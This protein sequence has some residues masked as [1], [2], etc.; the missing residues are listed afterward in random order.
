MLSFVVVGSSQLSAESNYDNLNAEKK[1]LACGMTLDALRYAFNYSTWGSREEI[2]S[3]YVVRFGSRESTEDFYNNY[4]PELFMRLKSYLVEYIEIVRSNSVPVFASN[5]V[6]SESFWQD[7]FSYR[8][9]R[10]SDQRSL[11][12]NFKDLGDWLLSPDRGLNISDIMGT[13]LR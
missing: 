11:S 7:V 3:E 12:A 6:E 9:G 2:V 13:L 4:V 1:E 5:R 10:L 8:M